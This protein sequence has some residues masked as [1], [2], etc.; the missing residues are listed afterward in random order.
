MGAVVAVLAAPQ[1]FPLIFNLLALV[2]ENIPGL[3]P[4]HKA[5]ETSVSSGEAQGVGG[6]PLCWLEA[7]EAELTAVILATVFTLLSWPGLV[8]T[9]GRCIRSLM[10]ILLMLCSVCGFALNWYNFYQDDYYLESCFSTKKECMNPRYRWYD[11]IYDV[12][13]REKCMMA[14]MS[15][16]TSFSAK[17]RQCY[18]IFSDRGPQC[19][20]FAGQCLVAAM[21][22]G[23][24]VVN[25]A[26]L[27]TEG[28]PDEARILAGAQVEE[29]VGERLH[30][31]DSR[32]MAALGDNG[33]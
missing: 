2:L 7:P 25:D 11:V 31:G 28:P 10:P 4:A 24:F 32:R 19:L 8:W 18:F 26:P 23:F 21:V 12:V 17:E 30:L 33:D 27:G 3:G 20:K 9:E 29:R 5:C 22:I 15:D 16:P 6:G 1:R 14:R 13:F